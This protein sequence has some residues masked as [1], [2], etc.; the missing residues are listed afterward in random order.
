[1]VGASTRGKLSAANKTVKYYGALNKPLTPD[2][3]DLLT[4]AQEMVGGSYEQHLIKWIASEAM[5]CKR[6]VKHRDTFI[7]L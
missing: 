3:Q 1:M 4:N 5:G 2:E 7:G 6:D